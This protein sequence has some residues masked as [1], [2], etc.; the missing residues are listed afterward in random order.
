MDSDQENLPNEITRM[1]QA[2]SFHY[3]V[4][5]DP[6]VTLL[7]VSPYMARR[8]DRILE[9][10]LE[11]FSVFTPINKSIL[12]GLVYRNSTMSIYHTVPWST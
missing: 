3:Y 8:F 11:P 7:F 9:F 4:L 2:F 1:I 12:A 10:L 5:I 6:G